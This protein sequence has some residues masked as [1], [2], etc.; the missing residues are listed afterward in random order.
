MQVCRR[1][2]KEQTERKRNFKVSQN[3]L[4]FLS[5]SRQE[6]H[7]KDEDL[8]F[9][10]L[11]T[12]MEARTHQAVSRCLCTSAALARACR[13]WRFVLVFYI[14]ILFHKGNEIPQAAHFRELLHFFKQLVTWPSRSN[15]VPCDTPCKGS[16]EKLET[17]PCPSTCMMGNENFEAPLPVSFLRSAIL[18]PPHWFWIPVFL[19]SCLSVT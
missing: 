6:A 9:L 1:G 18:I 14:Q 8:V 5:L 2:T 13:V 3:T 19:L 15:T 7:K 12:Q 10:A 4:F 16:Q 11:Q 17:G